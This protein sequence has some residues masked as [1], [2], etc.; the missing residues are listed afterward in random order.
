[1]AKTPNNKAPGLD[2][3]K[4]EMYK[5]FGS[6][7][8]LELLEVLNSAYDSHLLPDAMNKAG[9]VVIPETRQR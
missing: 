2:G 9:I 4:S 8:L 6:F 3:L 5:T 7:L 1:M